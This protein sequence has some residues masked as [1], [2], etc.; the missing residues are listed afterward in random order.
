MDNTTFD[1]LIA[2][3]YRSATGALP[4]ETTL[5]NLRAAFDAR[6]AEV[7]TV[8]VLS[9]TLLAVHGGGSDIEQCALEYIREYHAISPRVKVAL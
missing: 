8:D 1:K 7:D 3:F 9:G 6:I 5:E 4:W 2:D